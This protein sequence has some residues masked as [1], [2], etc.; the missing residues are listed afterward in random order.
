MG[1]AAVSTPR[2]CYSSTRPRCPYANKVLPHKRVPAEDCRESKGARCASPRPT[3]VNADQVRTRYRLMA[4]LGAPEGEV[5]PGSNRELQTKRLGY[6][7]VSFAELMHIS[8]TFL[9]EMEISTAPR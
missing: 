6:P 7:S 1:A 8:H 2:R 3:A 5:T 9:V 4:S